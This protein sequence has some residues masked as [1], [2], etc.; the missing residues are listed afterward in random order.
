MKV[1]SRTTRMQ[2]KAMS[3]RWLIIVPIPVAFDSLD[4][5]YSP[6]SPWSAWR[7]STSFHLP[8]KYPAFTVTG[9]H[10]EV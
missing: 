9:D 8:M 5:K 2:R 3:L 10:R 6:S 4:L 7:R 1:R